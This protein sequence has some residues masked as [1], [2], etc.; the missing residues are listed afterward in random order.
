MGLC[1]YGV[2][3]S[4]YIHRL[5]E[6]NLHYEIRKDNPI[7]TFICIYSMGN[8]YLFIQES[9]FFFKFKFFL[10]GFEL[11]SSKI[12]LNSTWNENSGHKKPK[13]ICALFIFLF[14]FRIYR[15]VN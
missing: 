15:W 8:F 7:G 5:Y 9:Y 6:S 13:I 4:F 1:L 14:L 11:F 12:F 2:L 10:L 3:D